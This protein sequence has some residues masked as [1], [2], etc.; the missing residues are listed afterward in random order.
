MDRDEQIPWAG[1]PADK[2]NPAHYDGDSC[3]RLIAQVTARMTGKEAACIG[4]AIKH[5]YRAGRKPGEEAVDDYRK[6]TWYLDWLKSQWDANGENDQMEHEGKV[7]HRIV[8]IVG[9]TAPECIVGK[10]WALG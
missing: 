1:P 6:A 5:I 2:I 7:I 8:Q 9:Y 10:L 4:L 3:M